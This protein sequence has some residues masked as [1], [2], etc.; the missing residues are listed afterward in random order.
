MTSGAVAARSSKVL[1]EGGL[2]ELHVTA[3]TVAC[4]PRCQ[5]RGPDP[6]SSHCWTSVFHPIRTFLE[7]RWISP[8]A[9]PHETRKLPA[10]TLPRLLQRA[11]LSSAE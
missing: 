3:M 2:A 1:A 7:Q 10:G 9:L 5:R 11:V 4:D 8:L 6:L